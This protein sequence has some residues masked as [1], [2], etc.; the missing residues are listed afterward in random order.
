[1]FT[2]FGE[3]P[4]V[5]HF[6][7]NA[8]GSFDD[9]YDASAAFAMGSITSVVQVPGFVYFAANAPAVDN[10]N[11]VNDF[12]GKVELGGGPVRVFTSAEPGLSNL[13]GLS[14]RSLGNGYFH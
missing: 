13:M 4:V 1:D 11:R 6:R 8:D 9:T 3:I 12:Q 10:L 14:V 2:D 5:D 7:I